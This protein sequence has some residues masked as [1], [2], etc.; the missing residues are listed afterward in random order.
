[1]QYE[2]GKW[3]KKSLKTS[4]Q[5]RPLEGQVY[6]YVGILSYLLTSWSRVLLE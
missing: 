2:R 4:H 1:M 3:K 5:D 6:L